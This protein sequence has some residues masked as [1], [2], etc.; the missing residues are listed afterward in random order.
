MCGPIQISYFTSSCGVSWVEFS[1]TLGRRLSLIGI[2]LSKTVTACHR[3]ANT[4]TA[5]PK[6][7]TATRTVK[8][9]VELQMFIRQ[10]PEWEENCVKLHLYEFDNNNILSK[11]LN[12]CV[13]N[14]WLIK[15]TLIIK[16]IFLNVHLNYCCCPYSQN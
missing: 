14:V 9:T 8:Y 16:C 2:T 15:I 3:I 13:F 12:A 11:R 5:T 1:D 7:D 10:G 4:N 6:Q